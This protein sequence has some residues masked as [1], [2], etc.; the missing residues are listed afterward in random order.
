MFTGAAAV[1]VGAGMAVG[2]VGEA[3]CCAEW[4]PLTAAPSTTMVA[5]RARVT[6]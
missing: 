2:V 5:S 3:C 1:V 4:Q 6:A